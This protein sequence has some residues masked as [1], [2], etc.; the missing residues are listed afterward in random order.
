MKFIVISR[1]F[2]LSDLLQQGLPGLTD[3]I[4][5]KP[6]DAIPKNS[7]SVTD[8]AVLDHQPRDEL[9]GPLVFEMVHQVGRIHS[10]PLVKQVKNLIDDVPDLLI[11]K[12]R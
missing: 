4:V 9:Q 1:M 2:G 12:I 11:M 7:F 5:L 6:F 10:L 3:A 8:D